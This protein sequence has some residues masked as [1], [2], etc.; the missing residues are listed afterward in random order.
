MAV[1]DD[2][3]RVEGK[4]DGLTSD[5]QMMTS[6]LVQLSTRLETYPD[7]AKQVA[8]HEVRLTALE[9]LEVR[10]YSLRLQS[11]ENA[12]S[13][14]KGWLAGATAVAAAVGAL[15]TWFLSKLLV[16]IPPM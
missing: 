15:I 16:T 2:I 7:T 14:F 5:L 11:L 10:K 6:S 1:T 8:D 12:V 3:A 13:G 4:I 9:A